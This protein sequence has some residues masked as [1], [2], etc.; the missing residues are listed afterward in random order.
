MTD[1][2]YAMYSYLLD[3]DLSFRGNDM[4]TLK[5]VRDTKQAI[6]NFMKNPTK[7]TLLEI[8]KQV[9]RFYDNNGNIYPKYKKV[10]P[11]I[12]NLDEMIFRTKQKMNFQIV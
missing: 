10:Q 2:V 12:N 11:Y 5:I 6:D 8:D 9:K 4:D 1:Y 3:I 7:D